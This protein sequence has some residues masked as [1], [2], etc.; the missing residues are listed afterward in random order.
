MLFL[1]CR[2]LL[3]R[4]K[5]TILTLM[6]IILGTAAFVI[7]SGFMLGFREFFID[8]L[9]NN[10]AHIRI[11]AKEEFLTEHGLDTHFFPTQ[12]HVFWDSPPSGRKD[13]DRIENPYGW[14]RLLSA[15][16]RVLAYTPQ[17]AT[18]VIV[19]KGQAS[20]TTRLMGTDATQH[21]KV[22][23]IGNYMIQGHFTDIAA[24]ANRLIVGIDFLHKIGARLQD[25]VYMSSGRTKP[26]PYKIVGVYKTGVKALDEDTIFGSLEDAQQMNQTPSQV[27]EIAVKLSDVTQASRIAKSW[28]GLAPE[29]V[30]SW[31]QIN[32]NFLEVFKIQDFIRYLMTASI[33]VVAGFSIYNILN[34]VVNQKQKEIAILRSIGYEAKDIILLFFIQG[35][36]LG[37]LGGSIGLFVGYWACRYL[38]TLPFAGGPLGSGNGHMMVSFVPTIYFWGL[39]LSVAASI[40][41]SVLPARAAGKLT[42]IDIIRSET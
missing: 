28:S 9:I 8:Q 38:V 15:D 5:Q 7:I 17:L 19:T 40:I 13:N 27:N 16:K 10:N 36:V 22:T 14:Y 11:S 24:G 1:A 26:F 31:D 32:Q 29:K 42:P 12:K 4:K 25:T 20:A 37:F 3:S 33:L 39:L 21:I 34:M 30:Q 41:A 18:N 6:G 2:H 23:T 35:V